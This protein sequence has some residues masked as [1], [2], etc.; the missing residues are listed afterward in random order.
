MYPKVFQINIKVTHND[1]DFNGHVN[2]LKYLEWMIDAAMLHSKSVGFGPEKYKEIGSTWY[3]KSHYIEYKHPAYEN[4]DLILKT[5]I[6]EVGK[7]TSKRKYEIIKND[8]L[9]AFGESVWIYV[10]FQTHRPKRIPKDI[11]EKFFN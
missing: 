4:D 1:I 7:I 9:L 11:I 2:N 5:W 8:K 3:A 10:D 6:E